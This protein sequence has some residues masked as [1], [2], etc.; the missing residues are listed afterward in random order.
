MPLPNIIPSR[1]VNGQTTQVKNE[2]VKVDSNSYCNEWIC[3]NC[4]NS[5]DTCDYPK[6]EG[7]WRGIYYNHDKC[8]PV[9]FRE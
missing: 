7:D 2:E 1:K 8:L 9:R 5:W 3:S 4:W 6:S